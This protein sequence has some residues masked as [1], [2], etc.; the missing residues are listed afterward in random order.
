MYDSFFALGFD[1]RGDF[2]WQFFTH[3]YKHL[4]W[5]DSVVERYIP[6]K[7]GE[8]VRVKDV[9]VGTRTESKLVEGLSQSFVKEMIGNIGKTFTVRDISSNLLWLEGDGH[10]VYLPDWLERVDHSELTETVSPP[11]E[12]PLT[13]TE[14]REYS[15]YFKDVSKL[16]TIDVYQV[17]ELFE[18]T[19]PCLQH[20]VKKA[21]VT[22]GR[23]AGKSFSQDL[24]EIR[25]TA[26]RA[27][28]MDSPD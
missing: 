5:K 26:I 12:P 15:H 11:I 13:V 7:V 18:V 19:N 4:N 14:T 20:I 23:T 22:G 24:R 17:L 28:E 6:F 8:L 27:I 21:L 3:D 25:D 9:A 2:K 10:W 1:E 16:D